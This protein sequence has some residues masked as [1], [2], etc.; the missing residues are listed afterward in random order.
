MSEKT[1]TTDH[2]EDVLDMVPMID[3]RD[4]LIREMVEALDY[5]EGCFSAAYTEGL[6]ERLVECDV[7]DLGSLPD[8]VYRRL[9]P[10]QHKANIILAK[11]KCVLNGGVGE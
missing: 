11:A 3:E 4:D 7:K 10:A 1:Q 9:L 5:V 2:S 6:E 8:L